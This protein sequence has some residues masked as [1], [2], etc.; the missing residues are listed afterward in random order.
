MTQLWNECLRLP[1]NVTLYVPAQSTC[2]HSLTRVVSLQ[3]WLGFRKSILII[4]P[5]LKNF[6]IFSRSLYNMH[7]YSLS[8]SLSFSPSL[9]LPPPSL[10]LTPPS[11]SPLPPSHL[12][13]SLSFSPLPSLSPSPSLSCYK[14]SGLVYADLSHSEAPPDAP[15]SC[16]SC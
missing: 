5:S 11:I 4:I 14:P 16:S 12:S 10:P 13:L 9:S 3:P 15:P 7:H 2:A 1:V 8:L 6:V